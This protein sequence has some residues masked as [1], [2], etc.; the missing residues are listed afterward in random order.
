MVVPFTLRQLEY[1]T[2]TMEHGTFRAAATACSVS[3]TALAQAITDL[4]RALG[5]TLLLR[6]RS[7]GVTPTSEGLALIAMSRSLLDQAT[8]L[9]SAADDLRNELSGPL[10]IGCYST[11]SP[12]IVPSI[13]AGFAKPHP[14][15]DVTIVEGDPTELQT[16]LHEG[17]LDCV[18]ML[19]RQAGASVETHAVR[20]GR[21]RVILSAEHP[22]AERTHLS[23][24]L[25]EKE[26]MVLLDL[27]AVRANLLPMLGEVGIHPRIEWRTT[28]FETV[29]SLVAR[30]LGW[31][32]LLHQTP[33][34][35][36]YEGLPLR[37]IFIDEPVASNDV[38][39]GVLR[40]RRWNARLRAFE[41]HCREHF[42]RMD[43]GS[44]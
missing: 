10:R 8:E 11:L 28:V 32:V 44:S 15:L 14:R 24:R 26:P 40:G 27:P 29:R 1:F 2:A 5:Q 19:S 3:E 36:S 13:I 31:S 30:N 17:R 34:D 43:A 33:T 21:P 20:A 42:R 35:V 12:F 37:S 6:Q 41:E 7:R 16:Q 18:L 9:E 38:A 23:L 22:L 4:E 39:L 25:L